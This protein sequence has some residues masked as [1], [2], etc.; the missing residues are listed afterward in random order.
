MS[1]P[2][3]DANNGSTLETEFR[4][5]VDQWCRETGMHSSLTI[6]W[7]HPAYQMIIGMGKDALPF[8]LDELRQN[9]A[10]WFYAL[11]CIA[12][13]DVASHTHT[14]EEARDAWIKW[15]I[16]TIEKEKS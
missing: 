12:R 10:H 9:R 8:I 6:I 14:P 11:K 1:T 13:K 5:L 2:K 16:Q 4:T 3:T 7:T 15:I